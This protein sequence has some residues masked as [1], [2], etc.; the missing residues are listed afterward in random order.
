MPSQSSKVGEMLNKRTKNTKT[1]MNFDGSYTTEIHSGIVHFDDENGNLQ[2][3]NTD[4]MDEAD[5]DSIDIPV[6]REGKEIFREAKTKS[7]TDKAKNKLNRDDFDYQGLF[8]PFESKIPRNFKK[9][10][11]IGK[12]QN[13][14]T[15]KPVGASSS[16]G[17]VTDD[18]KNEIQ[19]QDAWNDTDVILEITPDGIK[20]TMILKTDRAPFKFSFEVVGTIEDDLTAGELKLSPAWLEDANKEHRDVSQVVRREGDM[21]YI[22]L[23][24]DVTGLV[25]PIEIDPTVTIRPDGTIG[26]DTY[27]RQDYPTTN[28]GS[29]PS[30]SIGRWNSSEINRVLIKFDFSTIPQGSFIEVANLTL[31]VT[32]EQ[33]NSTS[34]Y[35]YSI[36]P[37]S[38][39]WEEGTVT[40]ANQP[41]YNASIFSSLPVS[42]LKSYTVDIKQIASLWVSGTTNNGIMIKDPSEVN[43]Q[44]LAQFASSDNSTVSYRPKLEVTY[45]VPPAAP[46]VT[47]PNGGETWNSSHTV[48]W[49]SATDAYDYILGAGDQ[50]FTT[51]GASASQNGQTFTTGNE[52]EVLKKVEF[53]T[54]TVTTAGVVPVSVYLTN[55]TYPIN[56]PLETKNVSISSV[57]VYSVDFNTSLSANTKY[58]I[59]WGDS[60]TTG[61][62]FGLAGWN[63]GSDANGNRVSRSGAT[64]WSNLSATDFAIRITTNKP[65]Q[66]Q[67]Q[68][69]TNNGGS[70]SDIVALTTAGATSYVYDFINKPQTSTAKVRIRAYDG[71]A[72][73]P[74]DESDGVFSIIHN[75]APTAPTNLTPVTT[76][77]RAG[78]IRFGWTHNDPNA[79]AQSKFDLDY[80]LQGSPTWITV[81]QNT[82]NQFY[83]MPAGTL[84]RGTY[85]WRIRTYDQAD[86]SG[87]YSDIKTFLAGD[88]PARPTTLSPVDGSTVSVSMPTV[89]W[90][91]VGQVGYTLK[92]LDAT[93]TTTL[94]ETTQTSNNKAHTIGYNLENETNYT[95][96]LTIKN[97]DGINSDVEESNIYVS[98]TPP[99]KALIAVVIDNSRGS[100]ELTIDNP[101]PIGTE[102]VVS[103]NDVYRKGPGQT[104]FVRVAVDVNGSFVD[105]TPAH[106]KTYEY[107]VKSFGENG[108][109]RDSDAVSGS[110]VFESAQLALTSDYSKWVKM[111]KGASRNKDKSIE[112]AMSKFAGRPQAMAEYGEHEEWMANVSFLIFDVEELNMLDHLIES[113]ETLLY[114]DNFGKREFVSV[115]GYSSEDHPSG[116]WNVSLTAEKV[117]FVEVI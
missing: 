6:A 70:W 99:A 30:L 84:S 19:Y 89:Q 59:V 57:G 114:R 106:G 54:G 31:Q 4:L 103:S 75:L 41:I 62:E 12:G 48:E 97:S 76:K 90:S 71:S 80:R 67:I 3:I 46:T 17:Y 38:E 85:E 26:K 92:V 87:P 32:S 73:G 36:Y 20:E 58:V 44:I 65:L 45:N 40:W 16:K 115:A 55:G 91:S 105:Y 27:V 50:S 95:I 14:L 72:Y 98:Y 61:V 33:I 83:D 107:Y 28:Y 113:R 2:N 24:A 25:Y 51:G 63:L 79:D 43:D 82:I 112:R 21:T 100:I 23:V 66:Y 108:T 8:V 110:A 18:K 102:P 111:K 5:F 69:S 37:I 101:V 15:F 35:S 93:K 49:L 64:A 74:W 22:D 68:L 94:W 60:T 1:W 96:Q 116:W 9:G 53:Y 42:S 7:K 11:T 78:I 88:K 39:T 52:T 77:D 109:F 34:Q 10:Y 86:L 81:T 29:Q 117:Y 13:K 56:S 104:E 47:T